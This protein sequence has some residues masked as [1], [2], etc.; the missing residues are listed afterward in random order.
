VEPDT[1]PEPAP[2][3]L[4][5]P[6]PTALGGLLFLLPVFERLGLPALLE[7]HPSLIE[8]GVPE[9]LLESIARR[10][11]APASDPFRVLFGGGAPGPLPGGLEYDLGRVLR[12]LRVATWW[13]CLHC[14]GMGPRSLVQRPAR[15]MATPTHIDV[16]LDI[17]QADLR[18]RRLGLD[19]DP[20]WVPWLGRV[21]RFHYLYGES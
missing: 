8:A 7:A 20:G 6:V 21:V 11:G 16:L 18:A 4:E 2:A 14:G 9:R 15:V 17:R 3:W 10:L 12:G 19:I 1:G 13:W 5:R